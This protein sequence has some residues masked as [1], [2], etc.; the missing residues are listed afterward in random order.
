MCHFKR[1][2]EWIVVVILAWLGENIVR[3]VK[4]VHKFHLKNIPNYVKVCR[5]STRSGM[6]VQSKLTFVPMANA[7]LIRPDLKAIIVNVIRDIAKIG[8]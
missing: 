5:T 3:L 7:S 2:L 4:I 6:H 8:M 1:C